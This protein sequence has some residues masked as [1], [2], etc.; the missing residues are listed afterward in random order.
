M[1]LITGFYINENRYLKSKL[2]DYERYK[3]E[4]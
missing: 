4:V 2:K 3:V 1:L